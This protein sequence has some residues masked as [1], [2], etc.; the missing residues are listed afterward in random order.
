MLEA[1][2]G[3]FGK[4]LGSLVGPAW[5]WIVQRWQRPAIK[6]TKAPVNLLEHIGPASSKE[7]VQAVLGPPHSVVLQNWFYQFSDVLVQFEFWDD[8]G[9][10]TIAMGLAGRKRANTFP[11]PGY[12]KPLGVLTV[13]DVLEEGAS[14]RRRTTLRTDEVLV[15]IRRGPTGAWVNQVFGALM[16]VGAR[17]LVE[18]CFEW[19]NENNC[20]RTNPAQ[21]LVN[22]VAITS[23]SDVAEEVWFDWSMT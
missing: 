18:S 4:L 2:A 15:E 8:G 5:K 7:R 23:T 9:A 16:A 6:L 12:A 19:D 11:V 21:V 3:F 1:L 14:L 10:K 22:W 17:S 20:L 13:A